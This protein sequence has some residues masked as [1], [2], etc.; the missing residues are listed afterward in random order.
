M[1]SSSA[2]DARS[3]V[4]AIIT[5]WNTQDVEATLA[6]I[7]DDAVYTLYVSEESVPFAG[8]SNGKDEIRATLFMMLAEFDYLKFDRTIVGV[9][10]DVVKVQTQFKFHHRRTGCN[11][12]GSMRSVFTIGNSGLVVRCDEFMDRGLVEAFMAMVRV[13]E[14]RHEIVPPPRIPAVRRKLRPARPILRASLKVLE[15]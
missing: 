6:Y 7:D 12:E 9:V 2:I 3:V 5:I 10:D 1:E 13:R 14:S 4:E 11:L 8:V 15:K